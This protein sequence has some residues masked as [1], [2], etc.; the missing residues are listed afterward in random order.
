MNEQYFTSLNG[1]I[2]K[3]PKSIHTYNTVLDM[4]SDLKLKNGDF[5]KTKGYDNV[6]DGMSDEYIISSQGDIPLNNGLYACLIKSNNKKYLDEYFMYC[7]EVNVNGVL[8]TDWT[9]AFKKAITENKIIYL[10]RNTYYIS[11][12][13][14]INKS[15]FSIIGDNKWQ[16]IIQLIPNSEITGNGIINVNNN[17]V[18]LS[19]FH[20]KGNDD[21]N[22]NEKT[23][24]YTVGGNNSVSTNSKF[25][26]LVINHIK[27]TG[28]TTETHSYDLHFENITIYYVDT[29]IIHNSTDCYFNNLIINLCK[30]NGIEI[31]GSSN[32]FSQCKVYRVGTINAD[33]LNPESTGYGYLITGATN[34]FTNCQAQECGYDGF[35]ISNTNGNTLYNCT[36]DSNGRYIETAV[37]INIDNSNFNTIDSSIMTKYFL[38]TDVN[39]WN[40]K[41]G[42]KVRGMFNEI[43]CIIYSI[44]NQSFTHYIETECDYLNDLS[45]TIVINGNQLLKPTYSNY[46]DIP[47][48]DYT[49]RPLDF[50]VDV[51]GTSNPSY[52]VDINN[53]YSSIT[54]TN[55]NNNSNAKFKQSF[56]V[57][58][59]LYSQISVYVEKKDLTKDNTQSFLRVRFYNSEN[60]EISNVQISY[61]EFYNNQYNSRLGWKEYS[62]L[63]N[64]PENTVSITVELVSS[65]TSNGTTNTTYFRNFKYLLS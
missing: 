15:G 36:S 46:L 4:K 56:E 60:T 2:V 23:A 29:G 5:V 20:I 14:D 54:I 47:R 62:K 59:S 10:K 40:M 3:D 33:N 25:E 6:N 31:V 24:I 63:I 35:K 42:I 49:N 19:N 22:V 18:L 37:G 41:T 28:I 44:G 7:E 1:Y 32:S 52:N 30:Y 26:N 43:K 21:L 65:S 38:N 55:A 45:N 11:D 39:S 53:H 9:E 50:T 12:T 64:I 16:S 8:Y 51:S 58:S 13:L 17:H 34:Y 61:S 57:N 48:T 27:G